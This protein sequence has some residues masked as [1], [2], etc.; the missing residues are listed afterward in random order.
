MTMLEGFQSNFR[1]QGKLGHCTCTIGDILMI[2][3]ENILEIRK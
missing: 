1:S 3:L 2:G